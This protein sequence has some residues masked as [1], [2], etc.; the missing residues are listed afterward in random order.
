MEN[1]IKYKRFTREFSN[2]DEIQ[3][4]FDELSTDGWIII[5]YDESPKDVTTLGVIVV[6]GKRNTIL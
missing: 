4:F 3:K 6:A 1:F 2:E 5:S